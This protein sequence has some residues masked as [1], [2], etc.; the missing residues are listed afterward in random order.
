MFGVARDPGWMRV[1]GG[2]RD[3]SSLTPLSP[4]QGCTHQGRRGHAAPAWRRTSIR[5]T[6]PPP[7]LP[8]RLEEEGGAEEAEVEVEEVVVGEEEEKEEQKQEGEEEGD[9]EAVEEEEERGR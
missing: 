7:S 9:Q 4:P 3:H 5:L 8:S 2:S 1:W 6:I